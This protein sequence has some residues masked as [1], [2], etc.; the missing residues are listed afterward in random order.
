MK[1]QASDGISL[2]YE[3][4]GEGPAILMT[5]GFG[6]SLE[7]WGPQVSAF[8]SSNRLVAWDMRGH[9]ESDCPDDVAHYSQARAVEDMRE[10]L[11]A[12]SIDKAIIAGHSLGGFLSLAFHATHPERVSALL[13]Q[14]CGPGYR[15]DESRAKWNERAERRAQTI[16]QGGLAA[17][18]G[19]EEVRVSVQRSPQ[20]LANAARGILSQVDASVINSLPSISVPT[21]VLIGEHDEPFLDGSQYMANKI[22]GAKH[23]VVPQ[24]GHGVNVEKVSETNAAY[25]AFFARV[26]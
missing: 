11:D 1:H 16:E 19:G 24:A 6:A 9:G 22:P 21:L 20:G 12:L 2:R 14:G 18:G 26:G 25:A 7:M 10:L 8:E 5:H 3:V 13:L 15:R 17:L 23:V 4:H